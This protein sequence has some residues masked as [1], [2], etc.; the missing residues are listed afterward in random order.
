VGLINFRKINSR[1]ASQFPGGEL[2]FSGIFLPKPVKTDLKGRS[3]L[4]FN[5]FHAA[6]RAV[7]GCGSHNFRVHRA[8]ILMSVIAAM[9]RVFAA[10]GYPNAECGE[11]HCNEHWQYQFDFHSS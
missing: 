8:C 3:P 7:A 2:Q 11:R 6:L 10:G 1:E 9:F 4:F 5:K